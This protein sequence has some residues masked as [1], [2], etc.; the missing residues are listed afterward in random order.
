MISFLIVAFAVFLLIRGINKLQ[1]EKEAPPAEP[2]TLSFLSRQR[3]VRT[4]LRISH[5]E[6]AGPVTTTNYSD[7]SLVPF[8]VNSP[9][10]F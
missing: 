1:R 7:L 2:T 10:A 8:D 6:H 5:H 3:G 9:A 4:V